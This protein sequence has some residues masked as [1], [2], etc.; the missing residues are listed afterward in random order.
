MQIIGLLLIL[1][2]MGAC[3][4]KN[5]LTGTNWSDIDAL[6]FADSD[7]VI[8][9]YSFP[10]DSLLSIS[11][12]K[13]SLLVGN[14]QGSTA[15]S[16]LRFTNLP[17]SAAFAKYD[18]AIELKLDIVLQRRNEVQREPL[19]LNFY[20]V[21]KG[22]AANPDT[23]SEADYSLI[24][25]TRIVVPVSII[26]SDTLSVSLPMSLIQY[27]LADADSPT[28]RTGVNILIKA[29][30]EGFVEIKLSTAT[31]GSKLKFKYKES[32]EATEYTDFE[33]FA[34]MNAYSFT[35][36]NDTQPSPETWIL[37]N[38]A[39]QRMY[40]DLEPDFAMFKSET[41]A[42]LLPE[43]LK[44]LS[45]NKA[46]LV[47]HI[48][49]ELP[50]YKN[51][52]SYRV[53]AFLLKEKPTANTVISTL[54]L[55]TPQFISSLESVVNTSSDS[56][57]VNITPIIQAYISQK[58]F[59]D[60]TVVTPKGIVIMSNYE[61]KDFGEIEFYHPEDSSAAPEKRAYI[62]IKYTPPFL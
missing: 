49:D 26:T 6:S 57:V 59:S 39:P 12:N 43:E 1:I 13:K 60:D 52:S 31:S 34:A 15:M 9:G 56:L 46:E 8:G 23:L 24:P 17:D 14:W 10:A 37:S 51:T 45:I 3:T 44:R 32:T 35:H 19:A 7:A 20:Q 47:L 30:N 29:E 33:R 53:S 22:W 27:W 40:V 62:R 38:F 48:K 61:R 36:P 18:E 42:T 16:I 55:Q 25:D 21:H 2:L 11:Y 41:G 5:N 50:N 54:D 28:D 4:K 58:T